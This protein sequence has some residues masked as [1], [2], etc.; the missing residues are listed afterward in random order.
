MAVL[1]IAQH[2]AT[3][4]RWVTGGDT[5]ILGIPGLSATFAG[6]SLDLSSP[7]PSWYAVA[8]VVLATAC[9]TWLAC[10]TRY[11]KVLAAIATTAWRPPASGPP[12]PYSFDW[13][14]LPSPPPP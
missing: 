13:P 9:L 5:G 8:A 3:S 14:F 2:L 12:T 11:G 10:R 7:L 1:I 4:W 6:H